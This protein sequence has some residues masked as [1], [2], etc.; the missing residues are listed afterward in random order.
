MQID[1]KKFF[2]I[3]QQIGCSYQFM[4]ENGIVKFTSEEYVPSSGEMS[5]ESKVLLKLKERYDGKHITELKKAV[6][7]NPY[8]NIKNLFVCNEFE[9][10]DIFKWRRYAERCKDNIQ[11]FEKFLKEGQEQLEKSK[12]NK[13]VWELSHAT[14]VDSYKEQIKQE[15]ENLKTFETK[16]EYL[17]A[18]QQYENDVINPMRMLHGITYVLHNVVDFV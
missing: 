2:W 3:E 8:W 14:Q 18:K 15:K 10:S 11:L 7:D 12:L 17:K 1:S 13:S 16:P 9:K 5:M 6:D 4:C